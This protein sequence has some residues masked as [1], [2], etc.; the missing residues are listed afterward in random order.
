[1]ARVHLDAARELLAEADRPYHGHIPQN[2]SLEDFR[3]VDR[4][5]HERKLRL[6]TGAMLEITEAQ[7]VR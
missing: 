4:E 5:R 6:I 2:A 7:N 3:R 1:M